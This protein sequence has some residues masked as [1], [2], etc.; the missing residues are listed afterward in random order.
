VVVHHVDEC[1]VHAQRLGG[2]LGGVEHRNGLEGKIRK[3][4]LI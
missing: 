2:Q 4:R 1:L 3:M